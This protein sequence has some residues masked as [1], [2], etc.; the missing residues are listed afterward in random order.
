MP[1]VRCMATPSTN[2]S[3]L[4]DLFAG[5]AQGTEGLLTAV[6]NQNL[7][8][9]AGTSQGGLVLVQAAALGGQ[10]AFG[11]AGAGNAGGLLQRADQGL[12]GLQ[13]GLSLGD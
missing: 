5:L 1:G 4:G 3:Q 6:G 12:H 8:F 10:V 2:S 11:G 7:Q 13:L 9:P